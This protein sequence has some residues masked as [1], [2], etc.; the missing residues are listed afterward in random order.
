MVRNPQRCHYGVVRVLESSKS[1]GFTLKTQFYGPISSKCS[2]L[3]VFCG[4]QNGFSSQARGG[5][6]KR[7]ASAVERYLR[8]Y[9]IGFQKSSIPNP[10]FSDGQ[11]CALGSLVHVKYKLVES[12]II[13][14]LVLGCDQAMRSAYAFA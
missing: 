8:R 5:I 1:C 11:R 10:L 4:L 13:N 12:C 9:N 7:R 2:R 14:T 6:P 3:R